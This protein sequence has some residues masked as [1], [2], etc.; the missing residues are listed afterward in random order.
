M[1]QTCPLIDFAC[2]A[3]PDQIL[4]PEAVTSHSLPAAEGNG[5]LRRGGLCLIEVCGAGGG[6]ELMV[7]VGSEG[8]DGTI[9][10]QDH[11]FNSNF[12]NE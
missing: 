4:H 2:I 9:G 12:I 7:L 3:T 11:L 1:A 5:G 8:G 6:K 10:L